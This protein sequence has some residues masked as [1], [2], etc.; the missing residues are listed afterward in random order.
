M[1]WCPLLD[2]LWGAVLLED[3]EVACHPPDSWQ[4]LLHQQDIPVIFAVDLHPRFHEASMFS[5]V[6][7]ERGRPLTIH[8]G[9]FSNLSQQHIEAIFIPPLLRERLLQ[10]FNNSKLLMKILSSLLKTILTLSC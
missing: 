4:H 9:P 2:V 3:E 10:P 6:R 5:G 7:T 8:A 1:Q